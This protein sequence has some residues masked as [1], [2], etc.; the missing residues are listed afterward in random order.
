MIKLNLGCASDIKEGFINVDIDCPEADIKA[1]LNNDWDF[2]AP[3]SV[4]HVHASNIF[5]HLP[6]IIHTMNELYKVLKSGGTARVTV[7]ST[8]GRGA[9]QDPT[10]KSYWNKNSWKYWCSNVDS[11]LTNLNKKYG[12][13]GDF[14]L[15]GEIEEFEI[16]D[17]IIFTSVL[18]EKI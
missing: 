9:F 8:D 5:E 2:V 1:D 10:H 16:H 6:D 13:K 7:P 14:K 12:F 4:D 17:K 3:E 15:I 11:G 18:L